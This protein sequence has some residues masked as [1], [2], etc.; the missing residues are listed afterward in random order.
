[1]DKTKFKKLLSS[2][3]EAISSTGKKYRL[4]GVNNLNVEFIRENKTK[5][6]SISIDELY[7]F[8]KNE[9]VI[10]TITA[11]NHISGRVQSPAVAILNSL[12]SNSEYPIFTNI[13]INDNLDI[14]LEGVTNEVKKKTKNVSV[15]DETIFFEAFSF[16]VGVDYFL[17]K[18]IGKPI[19]SN[20]I[21][22]SKNFKDYNFDEK[23]Q[24]IYINILRLL[25][26]N[27]QFQSDSL[28]HYIDGL[29][30][31]H[32]V[33]GTRIVEFDEE[34]H[35]TPARKDTLILLK[36]II[37]D[38][39]LSEYE[40]KCSDL[41]FLNKEVL[42]KH[43]LKNELKVIPQTFELFIE[44]LIEVKEKSSGYICEKDGFNFLGGRIA[45]R[46]YYDCLRDTAHLSL[47]NKELSAPLRFSK[48]TFEE[49]NQK[50]FSEIS[51]E[52][53]LKTIKII[54]RDK[55]KIKL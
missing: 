54:L 37:S 2:L 45:Q 26:S 7:N 49:I 51:K 9:S 11:R 38:T 35:F 55:Y 8:Y 15:K 29:V 17:S 16:L 30:I 19:S 18:S 6:E 32:S 3:K 39:Y 24:N 12:Q 44:W 46:A 50:N 23:V 52:D 48:K 4:F 28:S 25:K 42:K 27:Q 31:N 41:V 40:N 33:L 14:N 13:E 43:R 5:R 10:N 34:Q 1:M 20:D 53:L 21:F 22:L 47:K 36:N